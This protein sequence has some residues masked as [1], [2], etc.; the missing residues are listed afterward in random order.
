MT[1]KL[2]TNS[3]YEAKMLLQISTSQ[4]ETI[5]GDKHPK[6]L[7]CGLHFICIFD[8]SGTNDVCRKV[9]GL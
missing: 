9:P 1:L 6:Y 7:L 8:N 3:I 2:K 5:P 4:I